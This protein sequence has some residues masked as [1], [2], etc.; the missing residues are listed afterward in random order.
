MNTSKQIF[1]KN[2]RIKKSKLVDVR[3][4]DKT[5]FKVYDG[6]KVKYIGHIP[7]SGIWDSCSCPA[8]YFGMEYAIC[9]PC[10]VSIYF[11]EH[12]HTF[13]CKHIIAAIV[14]KDKIK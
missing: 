13:Q 1:E 12:G 3:F 6:D 4:Y 2:R 7:D 5:H 9:P 11:S 10:F 8:F 14:K